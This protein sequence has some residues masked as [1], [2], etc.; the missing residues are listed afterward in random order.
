MT[1]SHARATLDVVSHTTART[2][3]RRLRQGGSLLRATSAH[4]AA[5]PPPNTSGLRPGIT[6]ARPQGGSASAGLRP[7]PAARLSEPLGPRW[8]SHPPS[9]PNLIGHEKVR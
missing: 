6:H 8:R 5:L 9:S 2:T 7:A 1:S 4:W 3:R